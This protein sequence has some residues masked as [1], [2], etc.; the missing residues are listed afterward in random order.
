MTYKDFELEMAFSTTKWKTNPTNSNPICC[1]NASKWYE[2][3]IVQNSPIASNNEANPKNPDI[4]APNEY[5]ILKIAGIVTPNR[6]IKWANLGQ[7][8]LLT[9][10][11]YTGCASLGR[12]YDLLTP[13]LLRLGRLWDFLL[14]RLLFA[15]E[16]HRK[17]IYS[18]SYKFFPAK[19]PLEFT[20]GFTERK[21]EMEVL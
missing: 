7:L 16:V 15:T 20:L 9:L 11:E 6:I 21:N 2:V 3:G 12:L 13:L 4:V 1:S 5:K 8:D 17:D 18:E 19:E 14:L 10:D